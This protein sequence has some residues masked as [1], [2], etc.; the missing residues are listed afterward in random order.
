MSLP[1]FLII[2]TQKGGTTSLFR[3]LQKNSQTD[4]R[5]KE[6]GYFSV[7]HHKGLEWYESQIGRKGLT[8]ESDPNYLLYPHVPQ[9]IQQL[10]PQVKLVVLLRNPV[11]RA[12]SHWQMNRRN[13]WEKE[14]FEEAV[15]IEHERIGKVNISP[16]NIEDRND[17]AMYSYLTRG[18]YVDQLIE[19][20]KY[21]PREQF[22]ILKSED[23]NAAPEEALEKV[24]NFLGIEHESE[25]E[26][27][28]HN[29]SVY[30]EPINEETYDKL[31]QHFGPFN[32][33]L[34]KLL[35]MKFGWENDTIS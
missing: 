27:V 22:L 13:H 29:V 23:S 20:F 33:K 24:C 25:E 10:V 21:F 28:Q 9:R 4:L 18:Y 26:C 11:T 34:E 19:W 8:G 31:I 6:V 12:Y 2:G 1:D 3:N 35:G 30:K 16:E 14:S 15:K 7:R 32:E 17:F 5:R